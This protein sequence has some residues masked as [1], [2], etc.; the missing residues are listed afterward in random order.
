M[1]CIF[2]LIQVAYFG[3]EEEI[4]GD[5]GCSILQEFIRIENSAKHK[6]HEYTIDVGDVTRWD[7]DDKGPEYYI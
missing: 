3:D 1:Q 7:E 5:D 2:N 6:P 4:K